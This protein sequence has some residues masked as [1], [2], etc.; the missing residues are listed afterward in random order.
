MSH[1]YSDWQSAVLERIIMEFG[2]PLSIVSQLPDSA[3]A[4]L[5]PFRGVSFFVSNYS[6]LLPLFLSVVIP[7]GIIHLYTYTILLLAL[8]P[9]NIFIHSLYMGPFGVQFGIISA[10]HQ[11]SCVNNYIFK[12]FL[13]P[14]K[15]AKV[16]DTTLCI[17]GLDR[18]VIP[19]KLK[20]VIPKS[21]GS[22]IMDINIIS[23]LSQITHLLY[24]VFVS[25]IPILGPVITGYN[26]SI[27]ISINSQKRMW[28]L[29]RMR[30]R[31]IKYYSKEHELHLFIFGAICQFLESIPVIGLFFCFTN[32]C[33]GALIAG[34]GYK[35]DN[36]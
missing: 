24:K 8:L 6:R 20:R 2:R 30:P 9:L 31:Q 7:Y 11:C 32:T 4:I 17:I 35:I 15:L 10:F 3:D 14:G 19:G 26:R 29:T 13:I 34:D 23:L 22:K 5:Y 21:F 27:A 18:V 12:E 36:P 1:L 16:F 33:A 28:Q 25:F